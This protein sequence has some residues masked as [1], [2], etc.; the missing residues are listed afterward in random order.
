MP[1]G[2][3]ILDVHSASDGYIDKSENACSAIMCASAECR[4]MLGACIRVNSNRNC[5]SLAVDI[6]CI[7]EN[8]CS[9][10][11][12]CLTAVSVYFTCTWNLFKLTMMY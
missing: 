1:N 5:S 4:I 9:I 12:L 8:V 6:V 10:R 3:A 2:P 11:C 7:F